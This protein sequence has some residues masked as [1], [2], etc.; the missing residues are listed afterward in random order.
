TSGWQIDCEKLSATVSTQTVALVVVNPNNPT[1]SFIKQEELQQLNALCAEHQLAIISDEVFSDYG[2]GE[3]AQRVPSLVGN[4]GAL[5]FVLSGL[6]KISALPQVK[7]SWIHVSG[8]ETLR[9]AAQERL[10]F[11]ADTYLSVG[12]PV[13]H[14]AA[15]LLTQRRHVQKQIRQRCRANEQYLLA[16]CAHTA[17]CRVLQ[18]EGGWYAIIAIANE[19]SEEEFTVRLLEEY[20][21]LIHPGY[22]FD[23]PQP[24]YLVVSLLT[25]SK[26]FERGVELVLK[27]IADGF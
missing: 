15:R 13:Q 8:P 5:T 9:A 17:H 25:P 19:F 22:F 18:R 3:D 4:R 20:D 16:Q 27:R 11:I 21:V 6:S 24:G 2:E 23:F 1:G 14:A 7:L 26:I 10:D 12:T